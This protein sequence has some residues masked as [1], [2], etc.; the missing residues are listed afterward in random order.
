[1]TSPVTH[2]GGAKT[3]G[4]TSLGLSVVSLLAL[5]ATSTNAQTTSEPIG[6]LQV[7]VGV[8]WFGGA[9][10]AEQPAD[11]RA[12]GSGGV[13]RLF[14]S[15]TD[16]GGAGSFETRVGV[17]LTRR[18]G[19]EGRAA[20]SRPEIHTVVSSDA[21]MSGSF[22]LAE[23]IDQYVFDGGI[24]VRL[25]ELVTLGLRPFASAG[26]GYVRQLHEG[27]ELVEDGPLY[28]V[29]GG[30]THALFSR[31]QGL[32]RAATVRADLRLNMLSL[33]LDDG[34]RPQG[35]ISGSFVLMF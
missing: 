2:R 23:R 10:V 15:D 32:I 16:L 25:D 18:Y 8:G 5:G 29:G 26:V 4:I 33:E 13:Y 14:A 20:I 7:G 31:T 28:Y 9:A 27:R 19:I 34:A 24:V 30:F 35:S 6:R 11:L 21:E 22:T 17:A 1:M 12:G 3:P